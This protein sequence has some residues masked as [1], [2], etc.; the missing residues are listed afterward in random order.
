MSRSSQVPNSRG[1]SVTSTSVDCSHHQAIDR[2]GS[3]LTVTATARDGVIEGVEDPSAD[4]VVG[5]Q[6]HPEAGADRSLF[7]ALVSVAT[8]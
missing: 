2:L 8:R 5:V 4:F 7:R 6:W 3:G 1:F